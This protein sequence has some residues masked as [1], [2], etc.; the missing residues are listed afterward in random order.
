MA[1][2]ASPHRFTINKW[3][4]ASLLLTVGD[5]LFWAYSF[6]REDLGRPLFSRLTGLE[7]C[8]V[9]QLAAVVCGVIAIRR[10]SPAWGITVLA[11]T[12]IALSCFFGEL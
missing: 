7:Q 6:H 1:D 2:A 5:Y 4:V 3:G 8:V 9:V 12:L 10:G 11:A